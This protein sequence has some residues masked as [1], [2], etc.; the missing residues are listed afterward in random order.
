M[1]LSVF[2]DQAQRPIPSDLKD[3]LGQAA[4]LWSQLV[5]RVA[6]NH[7]P[8]AE[9]WHFGGSKY[10]WSLRLKRRD[11]IV[12]YLIPQRGHFLVG[13]VLG[14]KALEVIKKQ[15]LPPDILA[16]V[17]S[18]PRY[19]E[20]TGVRLPVATSRDVRAVEKMT[21]AKMAF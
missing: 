3:V 21:T 15:D 6:Q 5:S 19:G 17:A 20:G 7:P 12:L 2:E 10:G 16:A 13:L 18:S 8:I 4:G 9:L 14:E 1:A 11:R